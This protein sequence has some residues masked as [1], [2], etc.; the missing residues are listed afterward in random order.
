MNMQTKILKVIGASAAFLASTTVL[1]GTAFASVAPAG[2][3]ETAV[4]PA[5][6]S[7]CSHGY[8]T[9]TEAWGTCKN[10]S[11]GWGGFALTVQ[12]YYWGANTSYGNVPQTI[13]STCPSWSHI[14][15]ISVSPSAF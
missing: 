15:S 1:T 2:G 7:S 13:Y 11:G 4:T 3:R 14:T 9:A 5:T 8:V 6:A 12:C 10:E